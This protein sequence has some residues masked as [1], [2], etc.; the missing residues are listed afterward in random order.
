MLATL[1]VSAQE[2]DGN[3]GVQVGGLECQQAAAA[4]STLMTC[5]SGR[6]RRN[7]A[8]LCSAERLET[9]TAEQPGAPRQAAR[10][11]R[12][13]AALQ[14][15]SLFA[16]LCPTRLLL[17]SPSLVL[18]VVS[19]PALGPADRCLR[20][21]RELEGRAPAL[22]AVAAIPCL[23][24]PPP[25]EAQRS[26]SS[27]CQ[28]PQRRA[29]SAVRLGCCFARLSAHSMRNRVQVRSRGQGGEPW[30]RQPQGLFLSVCTITLASSLTSAC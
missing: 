19:L 26:C 22:A 29:S 14:A 24:L 9:R 23:T 20:P 7:N 12:A 17:P 5:W 2:G 28:Q 18:L 15:H 6:P 30:Q 13:T 10:A 8:A 4:N 16:L 27:Y 11:A 21:C 1:S 25:P 3:S